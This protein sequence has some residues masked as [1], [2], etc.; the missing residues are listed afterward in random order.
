MTPETWAI[1]RLS[2]LA[3]TLPWLET[4]S[5]RSLVSASIERTRGGGGGSRFSAV[6]VR[7]P[8]LEALG[9]RLGHALELEGSAD[10]DV[11]LTD[12]GP[13]VIDVNPRVGGGFP[14]TA[15]VH[16]GYV[17]GLLMIALNQRANDIGGYADGIEIHRE[18]RYYRVA[19]S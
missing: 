5:A 19:E 8:G 16:P 13:F 15:Q 12:E 9:K 6:S 2:V 3:E 10:V 11:I 7:D 14:F 4:S 1:S 18:T 17:D